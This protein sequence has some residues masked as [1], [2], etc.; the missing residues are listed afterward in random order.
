MID[1]LSGKGVTV[2]SSKSVLELKSQM[3]K[4]IRRKEKLEVVRVAEANGHELL[5]TPPYHSDI[6]PIE[7]LW[8]LVNPLCVCR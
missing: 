4:Y 5:F 1:C 7:L 8:A 6:Q 3:K 2:D